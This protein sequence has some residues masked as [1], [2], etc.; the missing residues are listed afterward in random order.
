[1]TRRPLLQHGHYLA[2]R[3]ETVCVCRSGID[4]AAAASSAIGVNGGG[5]PAMRARRA[6]GQITKA[7]QTVFSSYAE[8]MSRATASGRVP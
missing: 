6:Y 3:L 5:V 7:Q 1:M 8:Y 2:E 4:A